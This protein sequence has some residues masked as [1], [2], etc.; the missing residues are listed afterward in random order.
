ML[1]TFTSKDNKTLLDNEL[2]SVIASALE[3]LDSRFPLSD[4]INQVSERLARLTGDPR[5][6]ERM[7]VETSE[8]AKDV[9]GDSEGGSECD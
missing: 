9:A 6:T 4:N 1:L 5:H 2:K 8:L 7:R 3:E